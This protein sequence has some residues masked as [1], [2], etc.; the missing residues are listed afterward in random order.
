VDDIKDYVTI[1]RQVG[2]Q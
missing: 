2:K 1:N